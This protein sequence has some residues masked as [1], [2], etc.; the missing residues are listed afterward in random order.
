MSCALCVITIGGGLL[1]ARRLGISDLVFAIWAS[2]FNTAVA[3]FLAS[4]I[5]HTIIGNRFLLA[6][7]FYLTAYLY[8]SKTGQMNEG[9]FLGMTIGTGAF[10]AAYLIDQSI[11]LFPFQKVI[12]P[13]FLLLL[14]T[15]LAAAY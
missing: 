10:I 13:L 9:V 15:L 5:K 12:I 4:K 6:A 7:L 14:A 1:I 11:R 3:F 2:G 8:F